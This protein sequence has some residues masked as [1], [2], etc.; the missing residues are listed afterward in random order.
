MS[1]VRFEING[2]EDQFRV[3]LLLTGLINTSERHGLI[4]HIRDNRKAWR[5]K[6]CGRGRT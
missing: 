2:M 6:H 5:K 4:K 1:L 3:A